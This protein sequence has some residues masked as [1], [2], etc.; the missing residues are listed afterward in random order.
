MVLLN[1]SDM[2]VPTSAKCRQFS[3]NYILKF[4]KT[5]VSVLPFL[6][7]SVMLYDSAV[8]VLAVQDRQWHTELFEECSYLVSVLVAMKSWLVVCLQLRL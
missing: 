6:L 4:G 1:S 5:T 7:N 2:S 3:L 8:G